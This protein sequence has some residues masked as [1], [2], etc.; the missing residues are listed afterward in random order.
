MTN[1]EWLIQNG[2]HFSDLV[3]N[4]IPNN[5]DLYDVYCNGKRVG[6]TKNLW[7][8]GRIKGRNN[9]LKWLDEEH[10]EPLLTDEQ[11]TYLKAVIEPFRDDIS[12]IDLDVSD[13]GVSRLRI[14]VHT[15]H[16]WEMILLPS[17]MKFS[18]LKAGKQYQI[19]EL[20]L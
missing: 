3:L 4:T 9:L 6:Q 11:R 18:G 5:G 14:F 2:Y 10:K 20:G 1:G 8:G 13:D 15:N 17:S 7:R 19:G 12:A 16:D